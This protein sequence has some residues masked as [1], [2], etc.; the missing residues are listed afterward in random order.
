MNLTKGPRLL[1]RV[2]EEAYAAF[3]TAFSQR[4]ELSFHWVDGGMSHFR[5]LKIR[6]S[7]KQ[8]RRPVM[9]EVKEFY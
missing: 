4:T 3:Y 5:P 6:N 7:W 2:R 1:V 9:K 8:G